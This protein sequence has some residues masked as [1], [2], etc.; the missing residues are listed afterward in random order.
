MRS[1]ACTGPRWRASWW[2][3][4]VYGSALLGCRTT[5][6]TPIEQSYTGPCEHGWVLARYISLSKDQ[7]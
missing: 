7:N 1:T 6:L 3:N 2:L 5:I 4:V